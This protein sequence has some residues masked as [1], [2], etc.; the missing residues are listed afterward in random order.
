MESHDACSAAREVTGGSGAYRGRLHTA[1]LEFL[2]CGRSS[3][4]S[5][6]ELKLA[7]GA[8]D[9]QGLGSHDAVWSSKIAES[10]SLGSQLGA[11]VFVFEGG[12]GQSIE[13]PEGGL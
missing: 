3:L 4:G 9:A 2:K 1:I 12:V 8:I 13:Q 10:G 11:L 5:F 6:D 7:L